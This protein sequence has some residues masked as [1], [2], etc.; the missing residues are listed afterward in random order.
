MLSLYK[1][2]LRLALA[3]CKRFTNVGYRAKAR[4]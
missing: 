4:I 3:L 2:C 1:L